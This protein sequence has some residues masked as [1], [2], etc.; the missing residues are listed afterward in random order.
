MDKI[1]V[2]V[3]GVGYLGEH[4]ARIYASMDDVELA[5]VVDIKKER[6]D[7]I[8]LK[9]ST[10]SFYGYRDLFSKVD[11]VS[12][13]VPTILHHSIALEFIENRIDILVEK[14]IT[15][16]IT[17]ADDLI[18]K[19]LKRGVILQ[20]GH[21]ERFNPAIVEMRKHITRPGFIEAHRIGPY[22]GRGIDVDVI[23]DLM[24][25]DIDIILSITD[26]D[27]TDLRAIGVPVLTDHL[28]IANGRLEFSS[29]CIANITASRVSR[30]RMRKIR[31]FQPD[32][33]MSVDCGK[34]EI[35]IFRKTKREGKTEIR[36]EE[37]G[38]KKEEP[39]SA[40]IRAFIDAVTHRTEPL[41][42]GEDGRKAL[43]VAIR[44]RKDAKRRL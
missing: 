3:V 23:L 1:R 5:G 11:A 4:H 38:L 14:P 22:V 40:E 18:E 21:V 34:Q 29:G 7:E 2:G 24:I 43:D 20:V 25:H 42:T 16:A 6:A 13:A 28:D 17:E 12:I 44:I 8:A 19:A 36:G 9:Y 27:I 37:K 41:V 39:L 32:T 35:A 30:E 10:N 33:Y 26:S 31:I 15:S